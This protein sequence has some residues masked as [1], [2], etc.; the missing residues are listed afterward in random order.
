MWREAA[1]CA[2]MLAMGETNTDAYR[3]FPSQPGRVLLE[4][5]HLNPSTGCC[6]PSAVHTHLLSKVASSGERRRRVEIKTESTGQVS[7]TTEPIRSRCRTVTGIS[8]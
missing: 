5:D 4:N 7:P 3:Q 6:E 2:G 8:S 1:I